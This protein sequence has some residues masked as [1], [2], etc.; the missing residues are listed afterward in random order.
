MGK[1]LSILQMV[2]RSLGIPAEETVYRLV[3]VTSTCSLMLFTKLLL[4]SLFRMVIIAFEALLGYFPS[5]PKCN[6]I[7]LLWP[8][9][10]S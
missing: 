1:M 6:Y 2:F 8:I 10:T 4:C 5:L 9:V 3:N 7:F